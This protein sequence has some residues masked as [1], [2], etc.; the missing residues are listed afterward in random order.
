MM[1]MRHEAGGLVIGLGP[2]ATRGNG[3]EDATAA[4]AHVF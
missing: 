1:R 4:Q 2:P 3:D